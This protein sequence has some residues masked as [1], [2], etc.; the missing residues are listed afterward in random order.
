MRRAVHTSIAL[1]L[2]AVLAGLLGGCYTLLKHP[3]VSEGPQES[4]FSRCTDCHSSYFH[5]SLYDPG[6]ADA[7]WDYYRLPWWY[8]SA[9]AAADSGT[10]QMHYRSILER[11]LAPGDG[12][13][14]GVNPPGATGLPA[15]PTT[16][17]RADGEAAGAATKERAADGAK[18]DKRSI[19]QRSTTKERRDEKPA[20]SKTRQSADGQDAKKDSE[21]TK[22]TNEQKK[23][24]P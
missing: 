20:D 8:Q 3:D 2:V 9:F 17:H 22:D 24:K 4:D 14:I 1:T 16:K 15:M 19:E 5:R 10:G 21:G 18:V 6:Y 23:E 11:E 12:G 7:W 13:G